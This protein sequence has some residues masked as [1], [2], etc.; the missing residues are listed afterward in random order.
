MDCDLYERW[1]LGILLPRLP[2]SIQA[3]SMLLMLSLGT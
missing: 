1:Q 2:P 3:M